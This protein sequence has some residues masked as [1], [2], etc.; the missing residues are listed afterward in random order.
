MVD[1][2]SKWIEVGIVSSATLTNTIQKLRA[3]FSTHGLS[4]VI[5]FDNGTVFTSTEFQ[6]FVKR[7]NIK[8]ICTAHYHPSSN[9]QVEKAVQTFKESMKKTS[10]ESLETRVARFLFHYRITPHS[11]TG[12]APAEVLMGRKLR[13]PLSILTPNPVTRIKF[14][15]QL[16]KEHYDKTA[17]ERE[18]TIETS[19]LVRNFPNDDYWLRGILKD[20]SGPLSFNI[21][22]EDGRIIR[23][24][25]DHIRY[26]KVPD[27]GGRESNETFSDSVEVSLP[28]PKV[29][30]SEIAESNPQYPRRSSKIHHPPVR[31]QPDEN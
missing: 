15:Q 21:E 19:V 10:S 24:H 8:H 18:L 16:Q 6:E 11:T 2:H 30:E 25:M 17:K 31:Y 20:K 3:I 12:I 1:A 23:R 29:V 28:Q 26:Y 4:E 13:S 22:L 14:K 7:N 27:L 5:V 9:G